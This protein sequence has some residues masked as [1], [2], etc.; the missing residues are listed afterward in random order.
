MTTLCM[1]V[2]S[3]LKKEPNAREFKHVTKF[4]KRRTEIDVPGGSF[5]Y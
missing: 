2:L 5:I 3:V 4:S 1:F